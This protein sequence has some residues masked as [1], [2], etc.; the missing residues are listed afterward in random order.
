MRS[1]ILVV[2]LG[3][4]GALLGC[5]GEPESDFASESPVSSGPP[6]PEPTADTVAPPSTAQDP[7]PAEAALPVR[8]VPRPDASFIVGACIRSNAPTEAEA[9]ANC[10]RLAQSGDRYQRRACQ[11]R[12][13]QIV[14]LRPDDPVAFYRGC[15]WAVG[16]TPEEARAEC[17]RRRL[18]GWCDDGDVDAVHVATGPHTRHPPFQDFD[19][20]EIRYI[21]PSDLEVGWVSV[22]GEPPCFPAGTPIAT[23]EGT[24]PIETIRVGDR[25]LTRRGDRL[26]VTPV[27]GVKARRAEV[28]L[29]IEMEGGTLHITPEH[30]VWLDGAW[31]PARELQVG[32]FLSS[33]EGPVV[34]R[35]L[36]VEHGAREVFTLRVGPPHS[37]F[38]GGVWVHNY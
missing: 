37:F 20:P 36:R 4:F 18:D 26:E 5:G 33:T 29:V 15:C 14:A 21:V 32:D 25:V 2:L 10:R 17:E 22:E 13:E 38:A 35:A 8:L 6:S 28:L 34:V 30:P 24:R 1:R 9:L 11:C 23:A 27:R 19:G 16:D 12:T 3:G 31:H 7:A